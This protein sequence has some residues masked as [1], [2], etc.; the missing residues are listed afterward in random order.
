M[1]SIEFRMPLPP[2][3]NRYYRAI[4]SI[5]KVSAVGR[6]YK[7]TVSKLIKDAGMDY[8][9]SKR[10]EVTLKIAPA[11]AAEWDIDNRCKALFDSLTEAGFWEDDKLVDVLHIYKLPQYAMGEVYITV[12]ELI[13][14]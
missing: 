1:N 10:L 12:E 6:K 8:G 3:L 11:T 2:S 4:R 9:I 7:E 14:E 5:L 13:E